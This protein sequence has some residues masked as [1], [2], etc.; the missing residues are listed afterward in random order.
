M[1]RSSARSRLVGFAR[2][3]V[4]AVVVATL[5]LTLSV[6][7][8]V[9]WFVRFD[10]SKPPTSPGE[11]LTGT[12]VTMFL[13]SVVGVYA[14]F[15]FDRLLYKKGVLRE[16]DEKL[17]RFDDFSILI[18][19]VCSSIFFLSV[20]VWWTIFGT[21]FYITPELT[22]PGGWVP[23]VHLVIGICALFRFSSAITGLG[24]FGLYI[25]SAF[26]FGLFHMLDYVIFLGIGY[27]LLSTAFPKWDLLKSALVTLF[28]CTGL[29]LLWASIEKF[30]YADW[31]APLLKENPHMTMG[32]SQGMF[33]MVAG[34]VEF[35]LTFALLG[36]A[37]V[38]GRLISLALMAVFV[39]A[40]WEFGIVDAIGH[41]MIVAILFVLIVRG[42]TDAREMLVLRDKNI[43]TEA[44]FMTGLYYLAFITVFIAYYGLHYLFYGPY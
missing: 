26:T 28:A 27:F 41:L 6:E 37:S 44:Y 17:K 2:R 5:F 21:T 3:S 13:A 9:K 11:L 18:I 38:I 34:Y 4:F 16:F 19:R 29:T 33:M 14:F 12:F 20:F 22:A 31:T 7:A 10:I 15:L 35:F 1:E 40:V 25:S 30:V 39:T 24:I 23:W 36:A 42:P 43:F 32:M 8:H